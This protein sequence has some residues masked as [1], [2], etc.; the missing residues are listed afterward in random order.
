MDNHDLGDSKAQRI[1]SMYLNVAHCIPKYAWLICASFTF[2]VEKDI[3]SKGSLVYVAC[4]MHVPNNKKMSQCSWDLLRKKLSIFRW[5]SLVG[6]KC[7]L[8]VWWAALRCLMV[9]ELMQETSQKSF[10]KF[11][12]P[13]KI[14]DVE[15]NSV[16]WVRQMMDNLIRKHC[17]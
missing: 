11:H 13:W 17:I 16:N 14:H 3:W 9:D 10:L 15:W 7:Q 12:K 5:W 2:L 4:C 8:G 1:C 6:S